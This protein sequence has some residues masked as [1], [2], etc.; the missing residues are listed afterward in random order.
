MAR[1]VDDLLSLSRIELT[2][3]AP[4]TTQIHLQPILRAVAQALKLRAAVRGMRVELDFAADLQ[5]VNGDADELSQVFQNLIDNAIKYGSG[6]PVTVR[7]EAIGPRVQLAVRDHGPGIPPGFEDRI[8]ERFYRLDA[9]RSREIGGSGLGLAIV[10]SQVE[11]I[12]GR[13]WVE[14]A[15]P[16]ARFVVELD[17]A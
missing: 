15:D 3:H 9:G 17:A 13:V 2:E 5:T 6:S 10:K 4:P 1:L 8:F 7:A 14:R 16:G 12:G 11:A